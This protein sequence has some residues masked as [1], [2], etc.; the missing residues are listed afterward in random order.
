VITVTEREHGGEAGGD[1]RR[2]T[3][4][5]VIATGAAA[6]AGSMLWGTTA[7]AAKSPQQLLD[8]LRDE[9]RASKVDKDLKSRLLELTDDAKK[10]L[11]KGSNES[12]RKTLKKQVV[13]LL[14]KSA[15]RHGLSAKQAGAWVTETE[16]VVAKIPAGDGVG[17]ANGGSVYVFNCY[18]EP[19]S[20]LTVAGAAVGSIDSW[21]TR[22]QTLYT[23]A[24]R[25]VPRTRNPSP[26]SFVNGNNAVRIPW[27]SFTGTTTVTI[28]DG[29]SGISLDDDL[30]LFL[31]INQAMLLT[32]RGR[33]QSTF[34]VTVQQS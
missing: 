29:S 22:G 5:A 8:A 30:I 31:A 16:R 9:I 18:N 34:P 21:S 26:G 20:S 13:P 19:I 11:K 27:D 4:R 33:V 14:E 6:Y 23:P 3:R 12:A 15:G 17:G 32:T 1:E 7:L 24:E 10:D 2:V 25:A 28:P